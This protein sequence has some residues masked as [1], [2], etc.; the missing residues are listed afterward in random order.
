MK[1]RILAMLLL[2]AM[3]VTALPLMVLPSL[4]ATETE[5]TLTTFPWHFT[6]TA[7]FRLEGNR[8]AIT[9]AVENRDGDTMYF[10]V[11]GH[12]GYALP[13]G[14]DAYEA[15]FDEEEELAIN[16]LH[17]NLLGHDKKLIATGPVLPMKNEYFAV[18]ALVFET[19][20]SRGVT[21]RHRGGGRSIRVEFPGFD[22][23]LFWQMHN[24]PYLCIE[25]WNGMPDF[26][27]VDGDITHK[28]YITAL[29][30]G[31]TYTLTHTITFSEGE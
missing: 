22:H 20:N 16:S 5:E 26:L 18:D 24:A 1:K 17:G 19:L 14:V 28:P 10:S 13:E 23:L 3:I 9:Y 6:F 31:K 15:V 21:L 11:G 27:D 29:D 8:L 4:A 2:V 7:T 12:E 25:P 30:G